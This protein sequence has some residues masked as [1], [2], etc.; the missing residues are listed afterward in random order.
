MAHCERQKL[1]HRLWDLCAREC[2]GSTASRRQT[3]GVQEGFGTAT[4]Q[5]ECRSKSRL[6]QAV[7]NSVPLGQLARRHMLNLG[8]YGSG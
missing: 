1:Q 2:A 7:E 8:G 6:K 3:G 5:V 4:D